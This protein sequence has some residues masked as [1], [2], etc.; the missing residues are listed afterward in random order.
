MSDLDHVPLTQPTKHQRQQQHHHHH[1]GVEND[2]GQQNQQLRHDDDDEHDE[3]DPHSHVV[4]PLPSPGDTGNELSSS[5]S[6]SSVGSS[7]R[8]TEMAAE[9]ARLRFELH[10]VRL[11]LEKVQQNM[12]QGQGQQGNLYN[13]NDNNNIFPPKHKMPSR[14]VL[15]D[16]E[17]KANSRQRTRHPRRASQRPIHHRKKQRESG[18]ER[19]DDDDE[20]E[21]D[22]DLEIYDTSRTLHYRRHN[23]IPLPRHFFPFE[24]MN[25]KKG[26]SALES[27]Q[28]LQQIVEGDH[29]EGLEEG[30]A[31]ISTSVEFA[32]AATTRQT[33]TASNNDGE[34][35]VDLGQPFWASLQDRA[36]WLV[37]LLV[38]QSLSSFI[39]SRNESLLQEHIVIV[40]FLTMLVGA[41]GNAGNQ[42]SVRGMWY[43]AFLILLF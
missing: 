37:G 7:I 3:E 17:I 18:S 11:E 14:N 38:L 6:D 24:I 39:I 15:S 1:R 41:G 30:K 27:Q 10:A 32:G 19:D 22:L 20:L 2:G 5:S 31:L 35:D 21:P 34:N 43:I 42:A 36:G 16:G 12:H 25:G 33:T 29:Q 26:P 9:N 40:Q 13:N 23:A 4:S 28:D 8:D